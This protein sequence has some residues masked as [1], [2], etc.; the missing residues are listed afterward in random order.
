MSIIFF[1]SVKTAGIKALL[2]SVL[3]NIKDVGCGLLQLK[4]IGSIEAVLRARQ[5]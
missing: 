1:L 2:E 4:H 3:G 5:V